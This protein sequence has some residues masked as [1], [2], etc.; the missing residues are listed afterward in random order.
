MCDKTADTIASG[1]SEKD[2]SSSSSEPIQKI[3]VVAKP[4]NPIH[5]DEAIPTVNNDWDEALA[6]LVKTGMRST[7]IAQKLT[8]MG[9]TNAKG[10]R[11][12]RK[13]VERRLDRFPELKEI[14]R[15]AKPE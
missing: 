14:Y 3:E 15:N 5:Q 12:D 9:Y 4:D 7:G 13:A 1:V 11:L 6:E 10:G 2:E 8:E